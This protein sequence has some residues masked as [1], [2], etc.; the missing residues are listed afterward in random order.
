LAAGALDGVEGFESDDF[1]S[2][3]D[4]FESDED[5]LESEEEDDELEDPDDFA[6]SARLSVR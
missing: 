5:D 2:D 1:E 4:D 3:E 6:L